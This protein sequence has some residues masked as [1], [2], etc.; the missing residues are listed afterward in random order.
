ML[1]V[2]D[3]PSLQF[4]TRDF[5][6]GVVFRHSTPTTGL[7]GC[8]QKQGAVF[9]KVEVDNPFFGPA[10]LANSNS[11]DQTL[12]QIVTQVGLYYG[13]ATPGPIAYN[14]DVPRLVTM[15][16]ANTSLIQR[17]NG[18]PT[19]TQIIPL[20]NVSATGNAVSI[21]SQPDKSQCLRGVI[22]EIVAASP[23]TP[24]ET[25]ALDDYLMRKHAIALTDGARDAGLPARDSTRP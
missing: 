24:N 1:I 21:G 5:V 19:N 10:I 8:G 2:A 25:R 6:I 22:A 16:R 7:P 3:D 14:D 9:V 12:P 18:I 4:G 23:V 17:I 15:Y 13:L 20:L 11:F